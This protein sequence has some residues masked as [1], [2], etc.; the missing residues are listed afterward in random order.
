MNEVKIVRD[1]GKDTLDP[2]DLEGLTSEQTD[3]VLAMYASQKRADYRRAVTILLILAT[4][5][6]AAMIPLFVRLWAWGLGG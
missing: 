5:V 6:V 4:P 1:R 2:K 3:K